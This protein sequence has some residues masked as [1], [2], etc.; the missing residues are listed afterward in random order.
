MLAREFEV[1]KYSFKIMYENQNEYIL[2]LPFDHLLSYFILYEEETDL[3]FVVQTHRLFGKIDVLQ[4]Y[5]RQ[6]E[7]SR[8]SRGPISYTLIY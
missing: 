5:L 6:E 2:S 8:T 3:W 7:I 1:P 4:M